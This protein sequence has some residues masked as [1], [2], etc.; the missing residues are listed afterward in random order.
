MTDDHDWTMLKDDARFLTDEDG[1]PDVHVGYEVV[2]V[3]PCGET[4]TT[5]HT[6]EGAET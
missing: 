4:K 2:W 1:R 5:E 6:L 3:C